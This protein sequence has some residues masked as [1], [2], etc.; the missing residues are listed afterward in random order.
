[1]EELAKNVTRVR[2]AVAAYCDK[3]HIAPTFTTCDVFDIKNTE[4]WV[5]EWPRGERTGCYAF[6]SEAG[7]LLYIG[8][9]DCL[10]WRLDDYFVNVESQKIGTVKNAEEWWTIPPRY[11]QTIAVNEPWKHLS[12]EMYL[13][14]HLHPSD[15]K[16]MRLKDT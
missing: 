2:D 8:R 3:H 14:R 4:H 10:A 5:K 7:A 1:M 6:Y 16:A 15:N 12:L 11:L 13:I 9:A